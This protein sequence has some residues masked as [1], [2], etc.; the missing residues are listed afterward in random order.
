MF[1]W[2]FRI[3]ACVMITVGLLLLG[4]HD[5]FAPSPPKAPPNAVIVTSDIAPAELER[6][7]DSSIPVVA[8]RPNDEAV[9]SGGLF[10]GVLIAL[11]IASL[12]IGSSSDRAYQHKAAFCFFVGHLFLGVTVWVLISIWSTFAGFIILDLL[13]WPVPVLL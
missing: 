4:W 1:R 10:A 13:I 7:V 9:L 6:L 3:D 12:A 5:L 11:G 2:F 8:Y